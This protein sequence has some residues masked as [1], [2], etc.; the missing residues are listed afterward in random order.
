[1]LRSGEDV[2]LDDMHVFE[3]SETLQV[4]T[5]IVKSSGWDFVEAIMGEKIYE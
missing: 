3:L 2:F 1:V 5:D 4:Q